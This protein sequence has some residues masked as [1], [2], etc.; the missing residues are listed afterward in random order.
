MTTST[1]IVLVILAIAIAGNFLF[2]FG[3]Y[4]V[5]QQEIQNLSDRIGDIEAVYANLSDAMNATHLSSSNPE[6]IQPPE[7]VIETT[8][9]TVEPTPEPTPEPLYLTYKNEDY[10][11]SLEYAR[12]WTLDESRSSEVT[13]TS[14]ERKQCNDLKT[15]CYSI[16]SVFTI[17]AVPN[18]QPAVLEDYFNKAVS[19][20]QSDYA[21]TAT[22]KAPTTYIAGVKAYG[23]NYYT[24]DDRG[25]PLRMVMQ[26][27]TLIDDKMYILTYSA[28]YS[29]EK[30]NIFD[31]YRWDALEMVQ[32]FEVDRIYKP[33]A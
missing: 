33:M 17:Q 20:L 32:S 28:P 15:E 23:L 14:P 12:N 8:E 26:F 25:D 21:I 5:Q 2:T 9:L 6:V 11:Y 16:F 7:T 18:P 19:D 31:T 30:D 4:S 10:R 29:V 24:K 3:V 13:F 22:T 27:Y 1:T